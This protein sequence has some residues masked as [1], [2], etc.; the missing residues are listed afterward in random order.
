MP[1]ILE[2]PFSAGEL[3]PNASYARFEVTT[4]TFHIEAKILNITGVW[5][6]FVDGAWVTGVVPSRSYTINGDAYDAL[7]GDNPTLYADMKSAIYDYIQ[8]ADDRVAGDIS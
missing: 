6:K 1:I 2:T 5:K 8:S 4:F 7:V 3:D